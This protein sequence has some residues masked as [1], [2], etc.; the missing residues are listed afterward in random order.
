M[1][2]FDLFIKGNNQE[3]IQNENNQRYTQNQTNNA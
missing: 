3:A 1:K 2:K